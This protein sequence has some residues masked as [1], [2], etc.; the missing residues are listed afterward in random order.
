VG[1]WSGYEFRPHFWRKAVRKMFF[2]FDTK[3]FKDWLKGASLDDIKYQVNWCKDHKRQTLGTLI[4]IFTNM[5]IGSQDH[6]R[7]VP[8]H[9]RRDWMH[10]GPFIM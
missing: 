2:G 8:C 6:D 7:I 10:P 9:A 5:F 4:T 1:I 3:E